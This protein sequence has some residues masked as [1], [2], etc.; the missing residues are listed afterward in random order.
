MQPTRPQT[1]VRIV[2]LRNDAHPADC[3]FGVSTDFFLAGDRLRGSLLA[4]LSNW[5]HPTPGCHGQRDRSSSPCARQAN[6]GGIN[7]RTPKSDLC[8]PKKGEVNAEVDSRCK[9]RRKE[10][11]QGK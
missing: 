10:T 3:G 9:D 6:S 4:A 8:V 11:K 2:G 7:Q 1:G 5:R